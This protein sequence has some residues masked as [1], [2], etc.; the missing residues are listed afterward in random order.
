M[1]LGCSDL[2]DRSCG[3]DLDGEVEDAV[4]G[5]AE[6]ASTDATRARQRKSSA[7]GGNAEVARW[8]RGDDGLESRRGCARGRAV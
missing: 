8:V 1:P 6:G 3:F 4:A 7:G 2:A 5:F